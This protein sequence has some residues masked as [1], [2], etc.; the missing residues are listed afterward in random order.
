MS[1]R[2][3]SA[4]HAL[5]LLA[6]SVIGCGG[7]GEP[8]VAP[9][10]PAPA[11]VTPPATTAP[12]AVSTPAADAAAPAAPV[13]SAP[14]G[15]AQLGSK[16]VPIPGA[17]SPVSYDYLVADRAA[18][19]VYLAVGNT[20]SLDVF[21]AATG[22]FTR[23]DGFKTEERDYHGKKRMAGPSAATVGDGV[24]YVGNRATSEV[25]AVDAKTLKLGKC[26]K[27]P[28]PTD[29][30][31]YVAS[32]KEVWVTTPHDQSLTVLDASKPGEL[33]AKTVIKLGGEVE[34]YAVDDAHGLFFTNT[35]DKGTTLVVDVKSHKLR[36]TWNPSCG[37]D[38]PR[39]VAVDAARGLLFVACTDHVQVLD[40][41][42]DG[43]ALGKLDTGAG[44]DNLDYVD[45]SGLLYVAAGKA[46]QITVARF[47]D[48]G[49]PSVVATG[50]T[51]AGARNAVADGKGNA[52]VPDPNGAAL[53][54]LA[55]K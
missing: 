16:A 47:D 23:V 14:P 18:G 19:R 54:I 35:E 6:V 1:L 27:L 11:S 17:T 8:P 48:K 13:A 3:R 33:K 44:V 49:V 10:S 34:G 29:G 30:V 51:A 26:L 12:A 22:G 24:V 31:S 9:A 55:P 39:G 40:A 28:T 32:A 5:P 41:A 25:C 45:A 50:T 37:S 20:G 38:G 36:S 52:Y 21:D 46:A 43:A 53:L 15:P 42:H 4:L 7:A 2:S